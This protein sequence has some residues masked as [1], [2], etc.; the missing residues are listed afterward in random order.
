LR[1]SSGISEG[2]KPSLASVGSEMETQ[3]RARPIHVVEE[4]PENTVG[5]EISGARPPNEVTERRGH[6]ESIV[7]DFEVVQFCLLFIGKTRQ[8]VQLVFRQSA[9]LVAR[10]ALLEWRAEDLQE[11]IACRLRCPCHLDNLI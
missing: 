5:L 9:I 10:N 2:M 6:V 8:L 7:E 4:E 1:D 11:F 3:V